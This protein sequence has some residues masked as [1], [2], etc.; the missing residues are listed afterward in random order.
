MFCAARATQELASALAR[1]S[2][3]FHAQACGTGQ[4]TGRLEK[5]SEPGNCFVITRL[6]GIDKSNG[7]EHE[8]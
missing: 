6:M 8:C 2:L 4:A 1:M 3:L 5:L 7:C